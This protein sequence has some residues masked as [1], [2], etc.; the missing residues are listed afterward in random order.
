MM[1]KKRLSLLA[2]FLGRE[3]EERVK[4]HSSDK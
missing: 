2:F 1:Q 4:K 3:R